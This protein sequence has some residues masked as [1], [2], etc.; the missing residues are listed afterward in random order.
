M[1]IGLLQPLNAVV[2]PHKEKDGK[3]SRQR[4]AWEIVHKGG[5]WLALILAAVTIAMGCL[6][7]ERLSGAHLPG[8]GLG[9]GVSYAVVTA[10]LLA[11]VLLSKATAAKAGK[12]A[13]MPSTSS[14][15]REQ[16][17]D[18][19]VEVVVK[20][21]NGKPNDPPPPPSSP[22]VPPGLSTTGV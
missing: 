5:G 7:F 18:I 6:K 9:I 1:V 4:V 3:H 12:V 21:P 2:R 13:K 22:S 14:L 16:S 20:E 19:Q 10:V 11:A 15:P 8:A 17:G